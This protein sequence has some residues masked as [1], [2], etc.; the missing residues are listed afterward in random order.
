MSAR[1]KEW[2][3]YLVSVGFVALVV[4]AAFIATLLS[5]RLFRRQG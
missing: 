4:A 5:F 3:S 1:V 2:G